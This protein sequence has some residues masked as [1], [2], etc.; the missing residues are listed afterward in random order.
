MTDKSS[1]ETRI[2]KVLIDSLSVNIDESELHYDEGFEELISVDSLASLQFLTA[3]ENEFGI[4][5]SDD[6]LDLDVLRDLST[7]SR[8]IEKRLAGSEGRAAP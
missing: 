5:F 4:T 3:V 7:L 1:I 8:R 2:R 6:E